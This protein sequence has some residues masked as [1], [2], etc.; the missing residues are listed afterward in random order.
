MSRVNHLTHKGVAVLHLD[1]SNLKPGEYA[2]VFA[3]ALRALAA[4]A[5]GSARVV[6]DVGGARFDPSTIVEFERFVREATPRCLANAVIG[7]TGIQ[8]V[9]WLGLKPL[10]RCPV[11]LHAS[12]GAGKDWVAGYK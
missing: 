10:Y 2:P 8:R 7:V 12:L 4:A 9:A 11:E 6:T 3:E 1:L 5:P